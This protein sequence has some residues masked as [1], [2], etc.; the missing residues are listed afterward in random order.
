VRGSRGFTITTIEGKFEFLI[1]EEERLIE[2]LIQAHGTKV[3]LPFGHNPAGGV[4]TIFFNLGTQE[5]KGEI[6]RS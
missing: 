3:H 1:G 5:K 6:T 4:R 2:L